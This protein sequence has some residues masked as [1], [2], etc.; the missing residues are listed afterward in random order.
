MPSATMYADERSASCRHRARAPLTPTRH[1]ARGA[2]AR[3]SLGHSH[4][5]EH[6]TETRARPPP[7]GRA[8][9]GPPAQGTG[10]SRRQQ[11]ASLEG[12][13]GYIFFGATAPFPRVSG[14]RIRHA[15][16]PMSHG[17]AA[18]PR[19]KMPSGRAYSLALLLGPRICVRHLA[20]LGAA[21]PLGNANPSPGNPGNRADRRVIGV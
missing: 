8:N 5:T 18:A 16:V 4:V 15:A 6:R 7:Q 13:A 9:A 17:R 12:K 3:A 10:G 2:A 19:L 14:P 11:R 20:W 1:D 21:A